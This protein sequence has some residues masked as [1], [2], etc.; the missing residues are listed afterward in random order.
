[1]LILI[2]I[3]KSGEPTPSR[4]GLFEVKMEDGPVLW[5]KRET[6]RFPTSDADFNQMFDLIRKST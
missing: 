1:M 5:S 4:T 2:L 3:L 6:E